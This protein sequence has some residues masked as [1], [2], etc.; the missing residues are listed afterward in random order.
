MYRIFTL[1]FLSLTVS[2]FS[3]AEYLDDRRTDGFEKTADDDDRQFTNVGLIGLTVT[4]F[5]TIGTRNVYWPNQPSC[6]YFFGS[7]IEHIY[8]GGLWIGAFSRSRAQFLVSTA[9]SDQVSRGNVLRGFEFTNEVGSRITRRSSLSFSPNFKP[10]AVSHQ[11]FVADYSDLNTR[12]PATGDTI[13]QHTPLGI[14]VHQE[15]YAWNFPFTDFF[16]ILNYTI[17]NV[18]A[19]TLDSVYVGLWV[20]NV[21]RNTN[22]VRPGTPGYFEHGATGYDSLQRMAY[23]FDYDGI[24]GGPPADSYVAEKLLGTTPFP[25]GIDSLGDL[26]KKTYFNAWRFQSSTGDQAYLSPT[27]DFISGSYQGRYTRLAQSIPQDKIDPL[28]LSPG[29]FTLMLSTGPFGGD[30]L[31]VSKS[32]LYP[33]DSIVV[34]YAIVCAKKFGPDAAHFDTPEQRRTLYTNASWAQRAYNGEDL[35]GNNRLDLGEDIVGRSDSAGLV[36]QPDGKLTRF[37]LPFPPRQPKVRAEVENQKVVIY[38][39]KSTAEQSVD[40]ISGQKDFEGYRIYRSN[41]GADFQSPETFLL[42]LSLAGEFDVP[43]NTIGYNT[44]FSKILLDSAKYFL[45]DTVA[46]WYQFPPKIGDT[47]IAGRDTIIG[48]VPHLNGWQYMYGISAFD[49]GDSANGLP[50][51]ESAKV[52]QRIVPGTPPTSSPSVQVGV[53]PNPYYASA[54]WDGKGERNRKIYFYNLPAYCEI[55][56]YTLAGDIVAEI[57]HDASTYNGSDIQWFQTH[58]GSQTKP[59]FAGGEHAWDLITKFDQAIATGL[60]L[61]SVKDKATGEVK[62]GKFLIIK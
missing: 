7:R 2:N 60:Y 10:N 8:Q 45:G 14:A 33:G 48:T 6:E 56:I 25:H 27:D 13:L 46:Y 42:N 44:G 54:Y 21:V 34:T 59:Q 23:S 53:Y 43:G 30:S 11:D 29:N 16:V 47:I 12:V 15:S 32:S 5:G 55:R 18:S 57:N 37:L 52:L 39:D 9:T 50:S 36:F 28:R 31:G 35:N 20:N 22:L 61:F 41:A 58:G 26:Y 4:N 62:R 40:P 19:D 49:R 3:G 38:W 51:L 24:P 17:H 1:L